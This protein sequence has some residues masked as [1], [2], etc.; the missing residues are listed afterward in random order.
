MK[1]E[2]I[3]L[4][5]FVLFISSCTDSGSSSGGPSNTKWRT[6]TDGVR[7]S[8]VNDNP[9]REILSTQDLSVMV[10]YSNKGAFDI[11]GSGVKFYLTGYDS[12]I[13]FNSP[14]QK[15]DS[16]AI[17]GKN[18]FNTEGSQ[19][20]YAHWTTP[21]NI[22]KDHKVDSFTTG[23]AVTSC[24]KYRTQAL[25]TVC[26]DPQKYDMVVATRCGYSVQDLGTSQGAPIAVTDIKKRTTK[27]T[28]SFEITIQN[29]GQGLPF[30]KNSLDNCHNS[31]GL[32]DIN[33]VELSKISLSGKDFTNRCQP[34]TT[35]RLDDSGKGI[36]FCDRDLTENTYFNGLMEIVLDYNY[37]DT[38]TTDVTIVNLNR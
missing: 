26:V 11:T 6:G 18:Q 31:L 30:I 23:L 34:S 16:G 10:E 33:M 8:F 21:V 32:K 2:Y 36:I 29:K 3:V 22:N 24:Y 28:V 12:S 20:A 25:P 27:D 4:I 37:R 9:P 13:F 14:I 15:F 35:I 19:T 1:K 5:V 17:G 7:M 38:M